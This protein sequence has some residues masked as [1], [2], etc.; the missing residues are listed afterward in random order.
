MTRLSSSF[1]VAAA[2]AM[3]TLVARP[4]IAQTTSYNI[5]PGSEYTYLASPMGPGIPGGM[6]SDYVLDF[7]IAGTFDVQIEPG[8]MGQPATLTIL[9]AN[10]LLTGNE[11]IQA[12]PPVFGEVTAARVANFLEARNFLNLPQGA[13]VFADETFPQLRVMLSNIGGDLS[14]FG[15]FDHTP[16]DGTGLNF[17]LQATP[18]PEPAA[19][20]AAAMSAIWLASYRRRS[21]S[22]V[23]LR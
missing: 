11:A 13:I 19:C 17:M 3:L 1:R 22:R 14:L 23:G 18:V 5:S 6:P 10:L 21:S 12:N 20:T 9:N 15:G 7:G 4:A 8:M 16:A 2:T